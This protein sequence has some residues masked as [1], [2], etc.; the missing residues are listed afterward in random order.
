MDVSAG[1]GAEDVEDGELLGDLG[2][3]S[4]GTEGSL[5]GELLDTSATGIAV[6][7]A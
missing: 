7:G 1:V 2:E 5:V 3:V 4:T 6:V